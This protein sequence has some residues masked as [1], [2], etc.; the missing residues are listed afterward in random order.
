MF[1]VDT[2]VWIDFLRKENALLSDFLQDGEVMTHPLIY[3]EL[4]VRNL[5]KRKQFLALFSDLPSVPECSREEVLYMIEK[6][7]LYGKG[8]GYTDAHLLC[9]AII[10]DIQLWTL[11][12]RLDKLTKTLTDGR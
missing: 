9:S 4:S 6:H 11:D 2:S 10:Y 8:I 3:G 7:K 1:L 12:K 5:S